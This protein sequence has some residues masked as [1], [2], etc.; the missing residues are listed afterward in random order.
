M[1]TSK[2]RPPADP[3]RSPRPASSPAAGRRPPA[4]STESSG[5]D[6]STRPTARTSIR[7]SSRRTR[8]QEPEAKPER[9]HKLLAQSGVGSRREMEELISAGR[10]SLNGEVARVGQTASQGDRV[11]VNGKLV[12][13][14]FSDRL[15]RVI[16][17]HKPEGEIVSRNDPDHRPNVFTSM[18]RISSGRW[19]AVGRLD[20]NTS[21]LLLLTTSGDLANRL[22][23]PRY[24]LVREYAV[25]I[26]G[27]ISDEVRRR[28]LDGVELDDGPAQFASFQDAGGEGANRWYRVSIYE[29]RNREVR[30]MFEAV[31]VFVSRL[32]RV[33]YGP[34]ALPPG[35]KRGQV[36]ELSD[37]EVKKLLADF[38]MAN[39]EAGRPAR[40]P[41]ER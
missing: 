2:R 21:G 29:G 16:I 5:E 25:R 26:L 27:E 30:R 33:R 20:F 15:P 24:Q 14:R 38:G 34:F 18:P 7:E 28:L 8:H 37:A 40:R 6:E 4:A 41:R 19:V 11:K 3:S 1:P 13:L 32:M 22:M 35:L 39:P 10:I 23:H 36:L 31:G 9:L 12:Q 17:Y